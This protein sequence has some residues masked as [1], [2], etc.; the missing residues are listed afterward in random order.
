MRSGEDTRGCRLRRRGITPTARYSRAWPPRSGATSPW[1]AAARAAVSS[2]G[3]LRTRATPRSCSSRRGRTTVHAARA[4]GRPTCWSGRARHL[5]RPGVR[6]RRASRAR[7]DRLPASAGDG[8][9]LLHTTGA[10]AVGCPDDY[11][12]WAALTGDGALRA[13]PKCA[14]RSRGRRGMCV[15]TYGNDEVGPLLAPASTSPPRSAGRVPTTSPISTAVSASGS[16]PSTSR[17]GSASTPPSRMST[18]LAAARTSRSSPGVLRPPPPLRPARRASLR[19]ETGRSCAS[20]RTGRSLAGA[21]GSPAILQR[22]GVGDPALLRAVGTTCRSTSFLASGSRLD[23]HPPSSSSFRAR[24]SLAS[25]RS[26]P[27]PSASRPRSRRSERRG[28]ASPR[29]RRPPRVSCAGHSH[30]LLAGRVM[31]VAA[32]LEPRSR[33]RLHVIGSDPA[34]RRRSTTALSDPGAIDAAVLAEGVDAPA[35]AR[36]DGAAPLADRRRVGDDARNAARAVPRP[37]FPSRSGRAR[38]VEARSAAVCDGPGRRTR[39]R[40][41]RRRRLPLMPVD[42]AGEARTSPP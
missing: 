10:A 33:G 5:A 19:G 8:R 41:R 38:W 22:S 24:R 17:M 26:R 31:L 29:G 15:R 27:P 21:D 1:S 32:A 35:G 3:G 6:E 4:P 14:R 40:A 23:D 20:R 36:H 2:A 13:P 12:R 18:L 11:D 42:P 28:R 39:R 7:A 37:L 25:C 30:S 9:L 16:S 34:R